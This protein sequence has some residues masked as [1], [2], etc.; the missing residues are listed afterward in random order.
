M[1]F[2]S[3]LFFRIGTP[4]LIVNINII[5]Y[6]IYTMEHMESVAVSAKGMICS[7]FL[8]IMVLVAVTSILACS[9]RKLSTVVGSIF[10]VI[11][12]LFV[13]VALSF[14]YNYIQCP[15]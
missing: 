11:Y 3:H 2:I 8:I 4:L 12:I 10:V 7:I 5:I 1:I 14:T 9:K 13:G 15:V 6:N